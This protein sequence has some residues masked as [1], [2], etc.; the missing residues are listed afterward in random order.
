MRWF[1]PPE[2]RVLCPHGRGELPLGCRRG[3]RRPHR[4][5][6]GDHAGGRARR[7]QRRRGQRAG[8]PCRGPLG[9]APIPGARLL[10]VLAVACP[11]AQPDD[12]PRGRGRGLPAVI[13][14][15]GVRDPACDDTGAGQHSHS[16]PAGSAFPG[17]SGAAARLVGQRAA[18]VA[19]GPVTASPTPPR[20]AFTRPAF[21]RPAF[22]LHGCRAHADVAQCRLPKLIMKVRHRG[23]H[24]TG[25][26]V[27]S[28]AIDLGFHGVPVEPGHADPGADGDSVNRVRFQVWSTRSA[29][30]KPSGIEP[31]RHGWGNHAVSHRHTWC[32]RGRSAS[33][34]CESRR[35]MTL[36]LDPALGG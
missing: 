13:G 19:L 31:W 5:R 12:G 35:R 32:H 20:P 23:R 2:E 1:G 27:R 3:R 22:T 9:G 16:A 4:G 7:P 21:T 6:S 15:P 8:L 17:A 33:C 11:A 10:L 14:D 30:I 29:T 26:L 24:E 25:P 28:N 36:P 34:G 18:A